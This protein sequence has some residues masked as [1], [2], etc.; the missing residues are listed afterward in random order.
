MT[1][2]QFSMIVTV[3]LTAFAMLCFG[4]HYVLNRKKD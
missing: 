2:D 4:L 1:G 3:T